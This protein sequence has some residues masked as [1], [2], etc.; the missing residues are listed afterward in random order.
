MW[1]CWNLPMFLLRDGSLIDLDVHGLLDGTC[2]VCFPTYFREV[3]HPGIMT[4][5]VG[6]VMD[7]K[8]G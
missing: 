6:M 1:D 4:C 7:H 8:P 3:V 2:D 5:V